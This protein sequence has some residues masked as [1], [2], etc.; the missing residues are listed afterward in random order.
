VLN[1]QFVD[2]TRLLT[3][4]GAEDGS[5]GAHDVVCG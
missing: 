5:E 4:E 2:C 1:V 3:G